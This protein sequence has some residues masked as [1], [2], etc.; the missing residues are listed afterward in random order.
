MER[1]TFDCYA[2]A[3]FGLEGLVSAELKRLHMDEVQTETNGVRFITDQAGLFR[4]NLW[5]HFSER[6]YILM[7][8]G[9]CTSF[10]DLFQ[11]VSSVPW[12]E[13]ADGSE[14][15][16]ITCKSVRSTL[17]SQRACQSIAKKALIERLKRSLH[18][19]AFQER[20]ENFSVFVSVRNDRVRLLLDTSGE[21]L[22]HRGYRTWNGKA[23][24]RETLAAALIEISPWRPGTRLHDPCC[25]TGTIPIEAALMAINRAPGLHRFFEMEHFAFAHKHIFR[26]IRAEAEAGES[27]CA[28]LLIS[29]TDIDPEALELA[30]RH[31]RQADISPAIPF[32]CM[33]LQELQLNGE[34]G[35]FICNPPYGER[36]ETQRECRKLYHELH[37]LQRR[38]PG[39]A[40]CAITSDPAFERFFGKR[41]DRKR[42][43]YNGR[44]ECTYYLYG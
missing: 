29:G 5:S 2:G 28:D 19:E 11:L 39:W 35:V 43:M 38:H 24:L 40:L 34:K 14:F 27:A 20:G 15:F 42:R 31:Q 9:R 8:E 41:A 33:P 36:M 22:A 32:A 18:R 3:A 26:E 7:A 13:Y 25:G 10:E 12:E 37:M 4:C 17:S 6:I 21:S 23:P 44:L 30:G 1:Q 16:N